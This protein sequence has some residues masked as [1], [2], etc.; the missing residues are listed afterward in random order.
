[1]G[2][3]IAI[4]SARVKRSEQE[5]EDEEPYVACIS[6][7]VDIVPVSVPLCGTDKS[8]RTRRTSVAAQRKDYILRRITRAVKY[9]Y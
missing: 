8:Y 3:L 2:I 1:M 6:V 5:S 4:R 7:D 9:S